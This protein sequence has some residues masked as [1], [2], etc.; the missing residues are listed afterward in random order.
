MYH[1]YITKENNNY[2]M[3]GKFDTKAE[4]NHLVNYWNFLYPDRYIKPVE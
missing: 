3:F 2:K 1:V 4:T